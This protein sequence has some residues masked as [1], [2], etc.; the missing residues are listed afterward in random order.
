M[1]TLS[2]FW[3]W[4]TDLGWMPHGVCLRWDPSL[5]APMLASD[6]LIAFAYYS[7]PGA[8][9]FYFRRR[10][11]EIAFSWLL[12]AFGLFIFACGT[13]HLMEVVV[14]FKGAYAAESVVKVVTAVASV[15][16]AA[17]LYKVMPVLLVVPTPSQLEREIEHRK[18][19]EAQ[20]HRSNEALQQFAYA[21][22]HDLRAPLRGVRQLASWIQEDDGQNLSPQSHQRLEALQ[23]RAERLD[24]LLSGLLAYSE[25]GAGA[26]EAEA[27]D[28]QAMVEEIADLLQAEGVRIDAE[29]LP[30]LHTQRAPFALVFR[31]LLSNA[32][33]HGGRNVRVRAKEAGP[34]VRFSVEDDGPGI[35][36]EYQERVFR[37]F[38]TLRPRDEVEGS[39]MGLSLVKRAVEGRGGTVELESAVGEGATFSFTWPRTAEAP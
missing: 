4:L 33:K 32:V 38:Q 16:T 18:E 34:F 17:A 27:V 22:S 35:P 9:W 37:L 20:L 21:A 3:M 19:A 11:K 14:L 36:R 8:L 30:V 28:T 7:I 39:G 5:I 2:R 6:L 25:L 29:E 10:G 1:E 23:R 12:V 15:W 13:T 24:H 31:N 26:F